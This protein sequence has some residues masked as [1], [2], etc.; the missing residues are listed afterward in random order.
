MVTFSLERPPKGIAEELIPLV[1]V[2]PGDR[3]D[4]RFVGTISK[5]KCVLF[6]Y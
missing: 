1:G 2:F 5:I 4:S 6:M 3:G